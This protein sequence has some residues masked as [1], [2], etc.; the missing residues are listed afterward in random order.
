MTT[1]KQPAPAAPV[2]DGVDD[3]IECAMYELERASNR[4]YVAPL[5]RVMEATVLGQRQQALRALIA[6]RVAQEAAA[7]ESR[8]GR[9][10]LAIETV[11]RSENHAERDE[12]LIRRCWVEVGDAL[13]AFRA[14][15]AVG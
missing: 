10:V 9:L 6:R 13:A 7:V 1:D 11:R 2:T 12:S 4:Y 8:V 3:E 5:S 15:R 14:A